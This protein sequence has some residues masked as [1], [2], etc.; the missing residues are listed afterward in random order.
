MAKNK[1]RADPLASMLEVM[2]NYLVDRKRKKAGLT[3]VA[4]DDIA[5]ELGE[6]TLGIIR[7]FLH[8]KGL[9]KAQAALDRESPRGASSIS[10]RTILAEKLG[11]GTLMAQNKQRAVPLASMLE[12]MAHYFV[13]KAA[14][15]GAER[16]AV[17]MEKQLED[18][19]A[20]K[21]AGEAR[22]KAERK[23]AEMAKQLADVQ[24]R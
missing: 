6:C 18:A 12:V 2:A 14:S 11:I 1:L 5:T 10:K 22:A 15:A 23:T 19:T 24:A 8:K 7:E 16:K 9:A 13:G 3:A 4:A 21:D 17:V 20:T